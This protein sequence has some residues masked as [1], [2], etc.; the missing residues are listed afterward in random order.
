MGNPGPPQFTPQE[1]STGKNTEGLALF[2]TIQA[3]C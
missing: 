3:V 2:N 1:R